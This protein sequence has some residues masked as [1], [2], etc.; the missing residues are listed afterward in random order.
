MGPTTLVAVRDVDGQLVEL[1][2]RPDDAQ[3]ALMA[4][5]LNVDAI[6]NRIATLIDRRCE[7]LADDR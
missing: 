2:K 6:T 1:V 3:D 7:L 4:A 5:L